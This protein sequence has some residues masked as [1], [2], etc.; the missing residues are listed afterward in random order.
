MKTRVYTKIDHML[1][2]KHWKTQ[3]SYFQLDHEVSVSSDHSRGILIIQRKLKFGIKLLKFMKCWLKHSNFKCIMK[4]SWERV[5]RGNLT[6]RLV[7]KI[8]RLKNP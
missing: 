4:E 7:K 6:V 3:N 2:Y 5:E 8:K 1:C